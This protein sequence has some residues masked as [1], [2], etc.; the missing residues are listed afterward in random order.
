MNDAK[1]SELL[2]VYNADSTLI[3]AAK[4]FVTRIVTPSDYSCNL[5]MVTYGAVSMKKSWRSFL[6]SL[7]N[8]KTFLHKDEFR[9]VYSQYR[10][11]KLPAIFTVSKD[12]LTILVSAQGLSE[13]GNTEELQKL[14]ARK[15]EGEG[16]T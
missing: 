2:F 3:S 11:I 13:V 5:C 9:K 14:L 7:P 4:D 6:D 15:L 8:K 16:K 1:I 12:G 10:K